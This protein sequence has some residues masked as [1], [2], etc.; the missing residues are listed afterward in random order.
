MAACN[1]S[2]RIKVKFSKNIKQLVWLDGAEVS[3]LG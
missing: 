1:V 2:N 3:A